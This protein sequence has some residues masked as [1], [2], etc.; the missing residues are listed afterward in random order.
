MQERISPLVPADPV[1]ERSEPRAAYNVKE[2]ARLLGVSE[3]HART[4]IKNGRI[5]SF[6]L[7]RRVLIP[8]SAL[9]QLLRGEEVD[10]DE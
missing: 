10:G 2:V 4:E 9:D 8:A 1:I 6:R 7:G 3:R 5:R